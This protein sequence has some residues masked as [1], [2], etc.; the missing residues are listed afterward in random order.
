MIYFW[1]W[2]NL[3][4]HCMKW[5]RATLWTKESIKCQ[6]KRKFV[7]KKRWN[8]HAANY[9]NEYKHIKPIFK[10]VDELF[11]PS[12]THFHRK[13][14]QK[15]LYI[16]F[17]ARYVTIKIFTIILFYCPLLFHMRIV[18]VNRRCGKPT[19]NLKA[20]IL[21]YATTPLFDIRINCFE[22]DNIQFSVRMCRKKINDMPFK[23][24]KRKQNGW[25]FIFVDIFTKVNN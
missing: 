9:R 14:E 6:K 5:E 10:L 8:Q 17:M 13:L 18:C 15:H 12:L 4:S 24:W 16:F 7:S 21:Q 11:K 25:I 19:L 3:Q 23:S 1:Q 2:N 20:N 22:I